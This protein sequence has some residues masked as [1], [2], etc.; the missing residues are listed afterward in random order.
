MRL[1]RAM[2]EA[3]DGGPEIGPTARTLG[4]RSGVDVVVRS[5]RVSP[6]FGGLSVA[7]GDPANLPRHRRPNSL[8]GTGKDPLWTIDSEIL[9]SSLQFRQDQ[10]AHG[11]IEPSDV[12]RIDDFQRALADTA[13]HW[14]KI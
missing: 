2:R 14:S 3:P 1:Y 11:M 10:P 5:G 8:G 12:M 13:P 7:P 6:G 4:V 9:G